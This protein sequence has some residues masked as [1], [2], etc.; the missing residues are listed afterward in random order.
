VEETAPLSAYLD[1][2]TALAPILAGKQARVDRLARPGQQVLDVGCGV[3]DVVGL[4]A[5][6][7]GTSGLAVGLDL[8]D[9]LL[10]IARERNPGAEF[11]L[12]DATTL[13]F[14][15]DSFDGTQAERILQHVVDPVR[16]LQ[17]MV[18]V[19]RPGG[20]IILVEPD[21]GSV[22]LDAGAETTADRVAR[23]VEQRIRHPHVGRKLRRWMAIA[24]MYDI[25]VDI[26]AH[27]VADFGLARRML[28]ID[29]TINELARAGADD[30]AAL[31]SWSA[32]AEADGRAGRF[33][34]ML[35]LFVASGRVPTA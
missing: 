32:Q 17:E 31:T 3:G 19:T 7:V 23:A 9:A 15:D 21:W 26:E 34:A 24:G 33:T 28:L 22:L 13:P 27:V 35:C 16:A 2:A 25:S 4:M 20:T 10:E 11:V 29:E 18:R 6:A 30:A 12:G 5:Q 14:P 1:E 8:S